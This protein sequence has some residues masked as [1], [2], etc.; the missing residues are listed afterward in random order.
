MFQSPDESSVADDIL[1]TMDFRQRWK[2]LMSRISTDAMMPNSKWPLIVVSLRSHD[3]ESAA[4]Q[5]AQLALTGDTEALWLLS[6]DPADSPISDPYFRYYAGSRIRSVLGNSESAILWLKMAVMQQ[7]PEACIELAEIFWSATSY[8]IASSNTVTH[9]HDIH[10]QHFQESSSVPKTVEHTDYGMALMYLLKCIA[11]MDLSRANS[12]TVSHQHRL[13]RRMQYR[14]RADSINSVSSRSSRTSSVLCGGDD[15]DM[16]SRAWVCGLIADCFAFGVGT[17]VDAR[18]AVEWLENGWGGGI[19]RSSSSSGS[20]LGMS[21]LRAIVGSGT[22]VFESKDDERMCARELAEWYA[23]GSRR[24][25]PVFLDAGLLRT[26]DHSPEMQR[27]DADAH[28]GARIAADAAAAALWR[29]RA[30]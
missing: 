30:E 15:I 21:W 12:G 23:T 22:D 4:E 13:R 10:N 11:I 18:K 9:L 7:V 17:R 5:V 27:T 25:R 28:A 20:L 19:G 24:D 26:T 6:F 16:L 29:A 8:S 2:K 1:K 3:F 14:A